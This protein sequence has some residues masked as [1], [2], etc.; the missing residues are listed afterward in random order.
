MTLP[1]PPPQDPPHPPGTLAGIRVVDLSQNLAGPYCTQ[2]L[3]DLG[4]DVVKVEPP[5]MGDAARAW[6]PP[7]LGGHSPLFLSANRNKRSVV[8]DLTREEDRREL[9][10]LIDGADVFV[11]AFRRGVDAR[12]GFPP[13]EIMA[14]N[15]RIIHLSVQAW[16]PSGPLADQPGFDPLLQAFSGLL[17]VTGTEGGEPAR[18]GTSVV[19]LGTGMWG[20][21]GVLAALRDR[22]RTGVGQQVEVSLLETALAWMG[23]HLQ[24]VAGGGPVPRALGTALGMIAPYQGFPVQDGTVMIAAANDGLFRKLCG[25]LGLE[26]LLEDPRFSDNPTRAAH[27][28]IL[29]ELVSRATAPLTRD[30]LLE[31]MRA[32]GVPAAPIHDT[33]EV[34]DDL[35]V[36]STGLLRPAPHPDI[37]DYLEVATPVRR[38]GSHPPTRTP[39]PGRGEHQEEI[40]GRPPPGEG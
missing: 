37:A 25:A 8:L 33:R 26:A 13:G 3:G 24:G 2:I 28:E 7:F 14:R 19:D 16:G 5:G 27:R 15:P 35:Q 38:D 34:L 10:T 23:Y 39:P 4:A 6:G 9:W 30:E 29:A 22:D 18:A 32:A 36:R 11:Q 17:S 21:L 31:T 20:A 1:P 12:L 40:L